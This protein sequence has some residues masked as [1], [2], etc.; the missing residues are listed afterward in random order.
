MDKW[1]IIADH[2]DIV[3]DFVEEKIEKSKYKED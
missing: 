1:E 2:I 3:V